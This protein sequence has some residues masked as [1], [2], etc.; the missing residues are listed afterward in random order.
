MKQTRTRLIPVVMATLVV[1]AAVARGM[2]N[3]P[4]RGS[5]KIFL[6]SG[7]SNMTGRGNLGRLDRPPEEQEATLVRFIKAPENLKKFRFLYEGNNKTETGWTIREDVFISLGPWP[8]PERGEEGFSP[9]RK[10]GGL[11]P[12]YGGRGSRGFGPELAI[13]HILG[14]HYDEPVVLVKIAFGNNSLAGNFRPPSSGGKL[15][16]KY[17]LMGETVRETIEH[18]PDI[19]PGYAKEQGYE[20]VGFFWNQGLSDATPG[21]AG[22]YEDNLV[23]LI[24]D[25]RKEL[26]APDMKVV[27]GI[28]GN[29]GWKPK[30]ALVKWGRDENQ[31]LE[32]LASLEAV[33]KAQLTVPNRPEFKGTVAA[34]ETRDFWR[35]REQHGGHG[36]ETHWMA[37]GET[38]WLIGESMGNEMLKLISGEPNRAHDGSK[39][40][41]PGTKL[42]FAGRFDMY[43]DGKNIVVV[44]KEVAEGKPWVWRARFWGH[45]PQFDLAMLEKGYHV[46]YCDVGGLFGNETAVE[47]WNRYHQWLT[48]EHGFAEKAVLEGMSRGGL[49]IYNWAIANPDKVAAIYGDAPVLDLRSWPKFQSRGLQRAYDFQS[50][51]AFNAWQGNPI[52]NL[53][54]LAKA[55]I[56]II[57]VVGDRDTTVPV[58]ENTAIAEKRYREMGGLIKVIHKEDGGH[59]PH[60][61]KD[62]TPIVEFIIKESLR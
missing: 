45:E 50:E 23:N 5:I 60:S 9:Y 41:F 4:A 14:D 20:L 39:P 40:I 2:D 46:V 36:T 17:P 8:H 51:E 52:D 1:S 12:H 35:P 61:L 54:A 11:A 58:S 56:P 47:R 16:D 18:F 30:E 44:P 62:P 59:H 27:I 49:I 28:T 21:A 29:W 26:E 55:K 7:Q 34:A 13:G 19:V 24:N 25:L 38:Y 6:L 3:S 15:G 33:Q 10:H 57:H 32:F 53:G 31:R 37:N 48:R 22:E 42:L 43:R